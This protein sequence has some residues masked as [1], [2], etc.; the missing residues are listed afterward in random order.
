MSRAITIMVT[1]LLI[2]ADSPKTV[3]VLRQRAEPD[4]NL[5]DRNGDG[6]LNQDEMPDELKAEL[7][8]WDT[9]RDNLIDIDEYKYYFGAQRE[10]RRQDRNQPSTPS[11]NVIIREEDDLDA[12][13][14]VL[15]VGKLHDVKEL[16]GWFFTL[17]TDKDGQVALWEWRRAGKDLD[18]FRAWDRN[19]DGYITPEEAI[20]RQH[21]SPPVA[22]IQAPAARSDAGAAPSDIASG[23]PRNF[24]RGGRRRSRSQ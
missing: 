12:R 20:Y 7:S 16:P 24:A 4:F 18:E 14:T 11:A 6:F 8:K 19:D 15:R 10:R 13:P 21:V 2:A 22:V 1:A 17:D 9:N 23:P 3:D 5:R